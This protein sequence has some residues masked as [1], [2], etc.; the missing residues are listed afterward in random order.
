MLPYSLVTTDSFEKDFNK[1]DYQ[2]RK[3]IVDKL[4][5]LSRNP[6]YIGSPMKYLPSSL[7]GL[8]KYRVGDYR[9]FF[10]VD[11]K[12]ETITLYGIEHRSSAYK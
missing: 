4:T 7:K 3:R 1:L 5:W 9:V 6:Q 2:M 12:N 11:R 10:W 8:H